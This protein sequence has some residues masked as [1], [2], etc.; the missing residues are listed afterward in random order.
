MMES[1]KKK[2]KEKR[3]YPGKRGRTMQNNA[4]SYLF[5]HILSPLTLCRFGSPY[6]IVASGVC[7]RHHLNIN[8]VFDPRKER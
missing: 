8:S 7:R 6:I 4:P 2:E 5:H 3:K 1:Q